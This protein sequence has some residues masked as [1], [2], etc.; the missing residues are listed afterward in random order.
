MSVTT[1]TGGRLEAVAGRV[2]E[3]D[4]GA[5]AVSIGS[6]PAGG[7]ATVTPAGTVTVV[8]P[9]PGQRGQTE[10][11]VLVESGSGTREVK[12]PL[13]VVAG[14]VDAGWAPGDYYALAT[15]NDDLSVV[16]PGENHRKVYVS[17]SS[18]ALSTADIARR[19]GLSEGQIDGEWLA[20]HPEYGGSEGMALD[21]DAAMDLWGA[22]T[23]RFVDPSSHH[24]L[25]ERGY[26]Y[27]DTGRLIESG[28]QGESAL[29]PVLVGAWGKGERPVL[30]DDWSI[31]QKASENIVIQGIE[32]TGGGSILGVGTSVLLD[33]LILR[34]GRTVIQ[35]ADNITLRNSQILDVSDGTKTNGIYVQNTEKLLVE[36]VLADHNGWEPDW[37]SGDGNAPNAFNHNFYLQWDNLDVT[38]RDNVSLRGSSF[39]AQVRSGGVVENNALLDNNVALNVK[40]GEYRNNDFPGHYSLLL[41]NVVSSGADKEGAGAQAWGIRNLAPDTSLV[42]NILAHLADPANPR[43]LADKT[44]APH[45]PVWNRY[46][47]F[48]DDTIVYKWVTQNLR[49]DRRFQTDQNLPNLSEAALDE[50]TLRRFVEDEAGKKPGDVIDTLATWLRANWSEID[51]ASELV[52]YFQ[53][54][55]QI[56]RGIRTEPQDVR[57][58]P[59]ARGDGMRW[60]NRLNWSTEDRPIDGDNVDLAGNWVTYAGTVGLDGLDLGAGGVL[61][62]RQGLLE[63]DTLETGD[64]GRIEIGFAGQFWTDGYDGD[65]TLDIDVSGGR[66]ANTG[67]FEGPV[68]MTVSGGEA[69]LATPGGRFELDG[70]LTIA[71]SDARVGFDG[72]KGGGVLAIGAGSEL[73]YEA[74]AKGVSAIREFRSGAWGDDATGIGSAIDLGR[75][76]TLLTL[77]LGAMSIGSKT[78]VSGL[79]S[80]DQLTGGFGTIAVEGVSA[81]AVTVRIDYGTDRMELLTESGGGPA[82]LLLVGSSDKDVFVAAAGVDVKVQKYE[83][84]DAVDLSAALAAKDLEGLELSVDGLSGELRDDGGALLARVEGDAL[85]RIWVRADGWEVRVG[86][87]GVGTARQLSDAGP[88]VPPQPGGDPEEPEVPPAEPVQP[89][90]PPAEPDEPDV[91]PME[92]L[93]EPVVPPTEPSEPVVDPEE[94]EAPPAEPEEPKTPPVEE[95]EEPEVP[96]ADPEEPEAPQEVPNRAPEARSLRLEGAADETLEGQLVASDADGDDLAYA[97]DGGPSDGSIVIDADGRFSYDPEGAFDE[98]PVGETRVMRFDYLVSD[99]EGGTDRGTVSLVI[100][101]RYEPAPPSKP[102]KP[103][104]NPVNGTSGMDVIEGTDG[105]D[106]IRSGGGGYDRMWGGEGAD[107]FVFGAGAVDGTRTSDQIFDFDA[108]EDILVLEAGA[109]IASTQERAGSLWVKLAGDGDVILIDGASMADVDLIETNGIWLG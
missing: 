61:T 66:F 51:G 103:D 92:E 83:A 62:V 93:E 99:G 14:S 100:E 74:G 95:L 8:L 7:N 73:A 60:D 105:A 80:A 15:D 90:V 64:G 67:A 6:D 32:F 106:M 55:F 29:H 30:G 21:E 49:D 24:L 94:P 38:F 22:I 41:D 78:V 65:E 23:G 26:E 37:E 52:N 68:D 79:A 85:D 34:D 25:F 19:E 84:D 9:D 46:E 71:G 109:E 31:F 82:S 18:D 16:E 35:G 75:G 98:L 2:I 36:N 58:V 1:Y 45:D 27:E 17:G 108:E 33:D 107:A 70:R 48:V 53:D 97:V 42:G 10:F 4:L 54:G 89:E 40:G 101:G 69:L 86:E 91:P 43:E 12:V 44:T 39:G 28:T 81:G 102:A 104:W 87:D 96:P 57:F 59:D 56:G 88:V 5:R 50:I 77:D 76:D 20:A 11:S 47:P 63:T 3:I 13:S 72:P